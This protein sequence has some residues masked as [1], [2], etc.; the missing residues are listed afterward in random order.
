MYRVIV[1]KTMTNLKVIVSGRVWNKFHIFTVCLSFTQCCSHTNK[2]SLKV[3]ILPEREQR[4]PKSQNNSKAITEKLQV[5]FHKLRISLLTQSQPT[6]ET[7]GS[8]RS[9]IHCNKDNL[10]ISGSSYREYLYWSSKA[11]KVMTCWYFSFTIQRARSQIGAV[12]MQIESFCAFPWGRKE[13][14]PASSS[15]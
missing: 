6:P 3:L 9:H 2:Y 14:G 11:G 10:S 5:R 1:I 4:N 13:T 12:K 7:S 15:P 8:T